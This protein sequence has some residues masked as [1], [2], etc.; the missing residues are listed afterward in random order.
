MHP[1]GCQGAG[2]SLTNSDET[3][4][5]QQHDEKKDE[6]DDRV[7]P[8]LA[9]PDLIQPRHIAHIVVR[10]HKHDGTNPSTIQPVDATNNGDDEKTQYR[11]DPDGCGI[12]L[13]VP[14]DKENPG[15]RCNEPSQ[16]ERQR[17]VD[18]QVVPKRAHPDM[19]VSNPLE[20]QT[21]RRP[22]DIAK[23][24]VDDDADDSCDVVQPFG[25]LPWRTDERGRSHLVDATETRERRDLTEKVEA[26]HTEGERDHEK[27]ETSRSTGNGTEDERQNGGNPHPEDHTYPR[28]QPEVEA[29]A[30]TGRH[31]VSN[32]ESCDTEHQRLRQ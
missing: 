24:E 23:N 13:A 10:Y 27:V 17:A 18:P 19:V 26:D 4:W 11:T 28:I 14:P 3:V 6:T 12:D 15:D 2:Y 22:C 30:A 9:E 20:G 29:L 5:G 32:H 31:R 16:C 8:S 25:E 21:E 1:C 7:E